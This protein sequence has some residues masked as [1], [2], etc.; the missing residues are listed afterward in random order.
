[1]KALAEKLEATEEKLA[2]AEA[3]GDPGQKLFNRVFFRL[4]TS[5]APIP[6][7]FQEEA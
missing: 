6:E 1:M 7:T 3:A 5:N 2:A 4:C